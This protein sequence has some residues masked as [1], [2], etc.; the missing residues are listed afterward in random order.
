MA[1][2][3]ATPIASFTGGPSTRSARVHSQPALLHLPR[4]D[5]PFLGRRSDLKPQN[6]LV[7]AHSG[8]LKLADFGIARAFT[9]PLRPYTHEVIT[10]WYRAPEIL[11]GGSEYSVP[12]DIW[13]VGTVVSEMATGRPLFPGDSEIDQLLKIFKV[14]GTP[15]EDVWP[16][17][18][19]RRRRR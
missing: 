9:V 13:S 6:M 18:Q 1:W 4:P 7:D 5:A 19:A 16:G 3:G 10:L 14:R 12:V 15:N 8:T 11:L 17:V 2:R